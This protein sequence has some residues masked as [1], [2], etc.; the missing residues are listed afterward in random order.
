MEYQES[1]AYL[2]SLQ[3]LRPKLGTETTGKLL[4]ALD[5]PQA[6]I[7]C[8]QIAGSNGKGS[9]ARMLEGIL[10]EAELDVG[11]Y[12]SPALNDFRDQIR[13]NGRAVPKERVQSFVDEIDPCIDRLRAADDTPTYFEVLTALAIHHFGVEDVD[14]AI[15]EVGIGGRYDATSAV[16]PVASAVTSVSL[17]HTEL[18]GD[19]VEEIARDKAQVAPGDAPLVTG[20]DGAALEAVREET[21]VITV[22]GEEKDVHA[23]ETGM[24]SLVESSV[25][26]EAGGWSVDGNLPLLG[27]HQA[28]NAGVAATLA[29]QLASVDADTIARGLR[30]AHWPGRFEIMSTDPLTVLDG[31]HNPDACAKLASLVDRYEFDD[32]HLV[33][34]AMAD[35]DYAAMR[36]ELPAPDS[37]YLCEPAIDRAESGEVLAS[38]FADGDEAVDRSG[39]VLEATDRALSAAG[40]ND[41]VLVTGSLYV[42]AEARDRWTRLVTPKQVADRA[43]STGSAVDGDG[44]ATDYRTYKTRL[45]PDQATV[46]SEAMECAGGTVTVVDD[47][48]DKRVSLE[49]A[50]LGSQFRELIDRLDDAGLGLAHFSEQLERALAGT[51]GADQYPWG[52]EP[53]LVGIL[54]VTPESFH[55]GGEYVDVDDAVRRAESMIAAGADV[56]DVGGESTRPDVDPVSARTEIERVVPVIEALADREVTL[57]IDTRKASVANAALEAGVEVV[58]DV[59]GLADPEM[60]FVVAD[61]DAS[62]VI[63]HSLAAPVDPARTATYDDVVEDVIDDL[64]EQLLLAERAGLERDQLIVDPGCGFG[65]DPTECF[66]LIDR[67]EEFQALGCPVMIGHSQKSMFDLVDCQHGE[68]LS[69]TLAVTTLAAERGADL[70]RVHDVPE[71]AA[72]IRTV[73]ATR[74]HD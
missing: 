19:T 66:E 36:S 34:G 15:L 43:D 24:A 48:S 71:N 18:L 54:N 14:V 46:V 62:L 23:E 37:V 50:G 13:V 70:V 35:K 52:E 8:V 4:S 40:E 22:G 38:T 51:P 41:C 21:N 61:H 69:P 68:R 26:I 57:S 63:T 58:N 2:E 17:E 31:S 59:S 39:S 65:K 7:E 29:R 9:T 44:A 53:A 56:V 6:G 11:I 25:S 3:R 55:D 30:G 10:R 1:V 16:D 28:T 74:A 32:L 64:T 47:P 72:T 20:A 27:Q 5:Q 60:R 42:V 49:V 33:F 73:T 45:R 12:T 67:L